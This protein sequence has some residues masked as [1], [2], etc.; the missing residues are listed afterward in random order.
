MALKDNS[1]LKPNTGRFYT[2][3]VGTALPADLRNP[4]AEWEDIGHTSLEDIVA[5]SSEGGE[6]STL[7]SLQNKTLRNST[8]PRVESFGLNLHQFDETALQL[9]YGS[10]AKVN[11]NYV[12]VPDEPV[13]TERAWLGVLYDGN[14]DAG[15]YAAK[16]SIFRSDDVAISDTESLAQLPLSVTPLKME[17][18]TSPYTFI[19]PHKSADV[20]P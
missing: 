6:T 1:T 5:I 16:A 18:A 11:G 12:E 19:M 17:G 9:Y 2:A 15:F 10:N 14:N 20:T 13:A 3:P 4:G 8:T 7:G